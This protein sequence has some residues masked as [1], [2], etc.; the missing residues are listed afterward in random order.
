MIVIAIVLAGYLALALVYWLR[1]AHAT[2]R[3]RGLPRLALEGRV[4]SRPLGHD[5]AWPSPV[6]TPD[7]W[8]RLS[9]IV[10]ACNEADELEAAARSLLDNGYPDLELVLV[11]D[12]STD[13]TGA[14]VDRLA[15]GDPRVRGV[16]VAELPAGWLGKV[17][18]MNRGLGEA[19]GE[20]VL[21]TDADVHFA[22]G[23]LRTAV[24]YLVQHGL[25]HLAAF[26]DLRPGRFWLQAMIASFIR[27]FIV[28]TRAWQAG[29]PRSTAF[30]GI[31]AFNLVRRPAL[32]RTE[33][34]AW[35]RLEVADDMGLGL[36]LKRAGARGGVVS[37]I[38]GISLHW[39]QSVGDF[40]RG[41]EKAY[42][43][44]CRFSLPRSLAISTFMLLMETA[45]WLAPL[46]LLIGGPLRWLGLG[47]L[48][49]SF[50]YL[51]AGMNQARWAR[52]RLTRCL[53]GPLVAPIL[54]WMVVRAALL[55][56]RRG[57]LLWRG[58]LYRPA[59]LAPHMR[60]RLP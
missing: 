50:A 56:R 51:L 33:G 60:V 47:G 57:G 3:M 49:V 58:T 30:L 19:T 13:A 27:Q 22:P 41:S 23:V 31:G 16:H 46:A 59:D 54:A 37:A 38:G 55:G 39:Y 15:A 24:A 1:A 36:L 17:H 28:G 32:E 4:S 10:P 45:P 48:A 44:V 9:V 40:L 20:L 35:L 6:P 11:D 7:R 34:L 43:S 25:D 5:E 26:P 12:R 29:D 21:F 42:A 18:A 14:I 8:P 53:A 52:G 2:W